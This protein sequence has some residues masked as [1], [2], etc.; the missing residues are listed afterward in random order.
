MS[1]ASQKPDYMP[2]LDGVRGLACLL[3]FAQHVDQILKLNLID[4]PIG[5]FG[6]MIFFALSGFLMGMLY[7]NRHCTYDDAAKYVV[8][9]VSRIAPAY[10][11]AILFCAVLYWII[12]GFSYEMTPLNLFRAFAF[13]GS[14][15]VFWSIP[16]EVQFYGFF[17]LLWFSYAQMQKGRYIWM[18]L[19]VILSGIFIATREEWGGILLPSKFHVFLSGFL[20]ALLMRK[21]RERA[22]IIPSWL[23]IFLLAAT[24]AY[25]TTMQNGD[26]FYHDLLF[27]GIVAL[28]IMALSVE[29]PVTYIFKTSWMRFLGAA[30]FSIYLFHEAIM[31]VIVHVL[32]VADTG[33]A[34]L[35]PMFLVLGMG[36]PLLF[37]VF[38]ERRL[39][40]EA[41]TRGLAIAQRLKPGASP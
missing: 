29:T 5:S 40:R 24:V 9:R 38:V 8:S 7:F 37:H 27:P 1:D 21:V 31:Q 17:L 32:P 33:L 13:I 22:W 41:K 19:C 12:P 35:M 18:A 30:S 16:P 25:Y 10:Y 39:N 23:Q 26:A 36:V 28:T 15:G 11:I 14:E 20:A 2:T 3:V 34:L 6:V 4:H